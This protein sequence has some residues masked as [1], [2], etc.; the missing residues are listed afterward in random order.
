[1]QEETQYFSG[2]RWFVYIFIAGLFIMAGAGVLQFYARPG[3]WIVMT[4]GAPVFAV[5]FLLWLI[6]RKAKMISIVDGSGVSVQWTPGMKEPK[7]F[8]WDE[9]KTLEV[10]NNPRPGFSGH[11]INPGYRIIAMMNKQAARIELTSGKIWFIGTNKPEMW[12][13][14]S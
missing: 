9:I 8:K 4:A 10:V 3:W 1:M 5:G 11:K 12:K 14:V 6:F 13:P 7:Q 2:A